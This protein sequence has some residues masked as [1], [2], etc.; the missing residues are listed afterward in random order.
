MTTRYSLT[1]ILAWFLYTVGT[2]YAIMLLGGSLDALHVL[3]G[4][5]FFSLFIPA[6]IGAAKTLFVAMNDGKRNHA[7]NGFASLIGSA[8][9]NMALLIIAIL[10]TAFLT[11]AQVWIIVLSWV[12]WELSLAL[13]IE[14]ALAR[15]G[16]VK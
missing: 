13:F 12:L 15:K 3:N 14:T 16:T 10:A 7:H 5:A 4:I 1:D 11:A 2:V 8:S 9:V 6:I